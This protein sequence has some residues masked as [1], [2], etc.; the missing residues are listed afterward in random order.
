M[1]SLSKLQKLLLLFLVAVVL[2][3]V[4]YHNHP[5]MDGL[6][7]QLETKAPAL[8]KLFTLGEAV[9]FGGM[10]LMALGL[11]K[12]LGSNLLVWPGK[13]KEIMTSD[14]QPLSNARLFWFGFICNV[15]GSLTFAGIGLYVAAEILPG[16][17][18]TLIPAS[19]VDMA[20]TLAV[21]FAFYRR[22]SR[23]PRVAEEP[24]A[25]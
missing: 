14:A 9:Y 3:S 24:L 25:G 8:F 11:G 15:V 18:K 16:G 2:G 19:L 10:I 1:N 12:S 7:A 5:S 21:R 20:F 4:M 6:Q 17:S 22:F 23:A 13:L